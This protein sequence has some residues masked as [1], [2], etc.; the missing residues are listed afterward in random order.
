VSAV[1]RGARVDR[2]GNLELAQRYFDAWNSRDVATLRE[3]TDPEV[4]FVFPR[5]TAGLEDVLGWIEAAESEGPEHLDVSFVDRQLTED[6]PTV[7][8]TVKRVYTWKE[9]GDMANT[10]LVRAMLTFRDDK[11]T[12][13]EVAPAEQLPDK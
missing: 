4:T 7:V 9:S 1:A 13:V 8:S 5:E 11:I 2:V 12:K 6:G 10:I 3:L